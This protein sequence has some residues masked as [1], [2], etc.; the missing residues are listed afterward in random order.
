MKR[1][2]KTRLF[3]F[4]CKRR[5]PPVWLIG[6]GA[7]KDAGLP[8]VGEMDQKVLQATSVWRDSQ[9]RYY[10]GQNPGSIQ[11]VSDTGIPRIQ[12]FIQ[13]VV[14]L[15]QRSRPSHTP[16]YEDVFFVVQQIGDT[17]SGEYDNPALQ[18]LI[19]KATDFV[20][21]LN[22]LFSVR[23]PEDQS[24]HGLA[25]ETREY[26]VGLINAALSPDL[27]PLDHAHSLLDCI[28]EFGKLQVVTVATLNHDRVLE[29]VFTQAGV[30]YRDGFRVEN[31]FIRVFDDLVF[32]GPMVPVELL[33]LHGS[34]GWKRV[35]FY[36]QGR[37]QDRFCYIDNFNQFDLQG[38]LITS[39]GKG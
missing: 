21:C 11:D 34:V 12:A 17:L 39:K 20:I 38:T 10:P 16:N 29:E 35:R 13:W 31:E 2:T 15:I 14:A 30:E 3:S 1:H 8:L 28:A 27:G 36:S 23:Y 22:A 33:K 18:P 37:Y 6:S 5:R 7:S 26:L 4:R 19:E 24:L 25:Y 9:G 32:Q